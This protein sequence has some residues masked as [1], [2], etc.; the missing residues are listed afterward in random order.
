MRKEASLIFLVFLTVACVLAFGL[1]LV[2]A[3]G[4]YVS[5]EYRKAMES[6]HL[7]TAARMGWIKIV[8]WGG[9]AVVS[10]VGVGGLVG[11]LLRMVWRRSRLVH[12]H[13]SG[14]FP[15]VEGRASGETYYHDPNRQLAGAVAY[16]SGPEGVAVRH[17][18]PSGQEEAQLQIATQAQAAQLVAAAS[19]G[20]QLTAQT[21]R[22]VEK[23]AVAAPVRPVPHLPQVVVL[24]E[25]IPGERQLLAALRQ[26]WEEGG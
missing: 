10:L 2:Q 24:D 18:T 15:V 23:V 3:G 13:S 16:G 26:D 12:P 25:A 1:G 6:L 21:R 5:P 22:L 20:Q 9:L 4:R 17:L 7:D 19:Q 8:F 14:I 11:G